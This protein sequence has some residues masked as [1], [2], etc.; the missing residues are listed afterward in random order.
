MPGFAVQSLFLQL[1]GFWICL[2]AIGHCKVYYYWNVD[3]CWWFE[4]HKWYWDEVTCSV[5]SLSY[6]TELGKNWFRRKAE[7][8]FL[9]WFSLIFSKMISGWFPAL[10]KCKRNGGELHISNTFHNIF[11]SP[12]WSDVRVY[13]LRC[14]VNSL[15]L[16]VSV[17]SERSQ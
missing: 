3:Y 14:W 7:E 16:E 6:Y 12:V 15:K 1:N 2:K 9:L 13:H 4:I 5:S 8:A 11:Y 10:G 17:H